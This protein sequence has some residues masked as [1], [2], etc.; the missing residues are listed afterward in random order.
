MLRTVCCATTLFIATAFAYA[1]EV[2]STIGPLEQSAII[3]SPEN[4]IPRRL[5]APPA[6]RVA[7]WQGAVGRGL[8]RFQLTLDTSGSVG[9]IRTVGEPTVQ[10][11]AGTS[12]SEDARRAIAAAILK[13]AAVSVSQWKYE[14]PQKPVT[15]PVQF[16]FPSAAE[17]VATQNPL[18]AASPVSLVPAPARVEDW[19]AAAGIPRVGGP[20]RPPTQTKKVNPVYPLAAQL[21]RVQGLVILEVIIGADGRVR[22]LR[23]LRSVPFL[24]EAAVDAVRQWEYTPAQLEGKPTPVVMMVTT[25]F[26]ID[27]PNATSPGPLVVGPWPAAEGMARVGGNIPPPRRTKDARPDFP[28]EARRQRIGGAVI[29]EALIGPDGKVKDVRVL[30]SSPLFDKAAMDAVRKWEYERTQINGMFIPVVMPVTVT[31]SIR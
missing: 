20:V 7:E 10:L 6:T 1:Q 24:D 14:A 26:S 27:A 28:D 23:V 4:P 16:V 2:R 29:L 8:L 15:F 9:E 19:P 18:A 3:P 21:E 12:I 30:R 5:S 22:D 25:T 13:S 11:A 17:P 31:F